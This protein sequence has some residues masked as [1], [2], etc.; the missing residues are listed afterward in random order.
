M[1][2]ILISGATGFIGSNISKRLLDKGYKVYATHRNSSSFE[3]CTLFRD[4]IEWIN[5]DL[6]EWKAKIK[7]IQPDQ[8]IHAAWK[9]VEAGERDRWDVQL[10]NFW[11][12]KEYFD[13][14][15]SCGVKKIIALGSQA[16]Y[17]RYDF[18]INEVT[19]PKPE[20]AY[21][22]VKLL[23]SNYLRNVCEYSNTEW[24]WLRIFSIFGEGENS[25]WLIP[26]VISHLLRHNSISL[27]ACEQQCNYLYIEDFSS[28]LIAIVQSTEDKSG[29]YNICNA[30][31]I[32]IKDLLLE[33]ARLMNVSTELLQFGSI[34][35]RQG[36]NMM[37]AG[38]K[39]KFNQSY[40]IDN[41][42]L[43]GLTNGLIR[44]ISYYREKLT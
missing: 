44:T 10:C 41:K 40:A 20:D 31:S 17:G 12:A 9:S 16:E 32:K 15:I 37:I 43:I 4:Q 13:L 11:L 38:D 33:I 14:A 30:E 25:G 42:S 29:I 7:T 28:Q 18:P 1:N 2:K 27:T 22:A 3:K 34:P 24:Y 35:Y 8:F 39:S 23:I 5:T 26:L 19:N 21:G 6:V 36:Q